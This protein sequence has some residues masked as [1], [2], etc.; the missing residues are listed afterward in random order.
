MYNP[1]IEVEI[2]KQMREVMMD[3]NTLRISVKKKEEVEEAIEF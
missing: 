2:K 3:R 1:R